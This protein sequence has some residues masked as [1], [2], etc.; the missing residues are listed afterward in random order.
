MYFNYRKH[1]KRLAVEKQRSDD[2]LLNILPSEV[3]TELKNTGKSEARKFENASVM[4]TDFKNFSVLSQD[5][6][7][8]ELVTEIDRC[9]SEFDDIIGRYGL[10]K[11]KTIGDA[12]MCAAGMPVESEDH[13]V[14]IVH[15]ALDI[16]DYMKRHAKERTD[17][18]LPSFEIRIGINSGPLVAGIVGKKKFA[19]D[20][21]G[22]TVNIASRMESS[23]VP[24]KV[25]VSAFT[26]DMLK[27]HFEL[28]SRGK[29]PV[30]KLGELE[31][32][33]VERA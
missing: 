13:A 30:K 24:G 33:F 22:D 10:E 3:A 31:Q 12:Y 20:I 11:I 23:G 4:F 17:K 8:E 19:Y 5:M 9:F 28:E 21:W 15:A 14:K 27:D 29:V 6:S 16:R 1:A 18:G 26:A 2:L 25:N 7:P 32:F